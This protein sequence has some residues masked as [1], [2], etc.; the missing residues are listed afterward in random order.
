V[1]HDRR[2]WLEDSETQKLVRVLTTA[3]RKAAKGIVENA[4]N[5]PVEHMRYCAGLHQG[6]KMA[7]KEVLGE[8]PNEED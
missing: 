2:E 4:V 1:N 7:L 5:S 3:V 8:I 6:L